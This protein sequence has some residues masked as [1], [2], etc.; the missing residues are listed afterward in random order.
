MN[1]SVCCVCGSEDWVYGMA[2][3]GWTGLVTRRFCPAHR[4]HRAKVGGSLEQARELKLK[5]YVTG[6]PCPKGHWLRYTKGSDCVQCVADRVKEQRE[7]GAR[8]IYDA[9]YLARHR[10]K[11]ST[12][13]FERV[14]ATRIAAKAAG[15]TEQAYRRAMK[16]EGTQP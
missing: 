3:D 8:K 11:Q 12:A 2:G 5:H 6:R 9:V 7:S 4:D 1:A 16:Q 15:M 13:F 10:P 14:Q